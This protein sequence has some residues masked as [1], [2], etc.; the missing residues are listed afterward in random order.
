[1]GIAMKSLFLKLNDM[2]NYFLPTIKMYLRIMKRVVNI[3][4]LAILALLQIE[5]VVQ[6]QNVIVLSTADS[7]NK[8]YVASQYIEFLPGYIYQANST[9]EMEAYIYPNLN[10]LHLED[11]FCNDANV[12]IDTELESTSAPNATSYS[13]VVEDLQEGKKET[14]KSDDH[15]FSLSELVT[16]DVESG[17]KFK[18]LVIAR[19]QKGIIVGQG[20]ACI[21]KVL[22]A[23]TFKPF[24]PL[25]KKVDAGYVP[26]GSDKVLRF[27]YYE[28]YAVNS[29]DVEIL[30]SLSSSVY[31]GTINV[32]TGSNDL[33]MDLSQL[34]AKSFHTLQITT[35]KNE[36]W[37]LRFRTPE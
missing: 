13:F 3:K 23:I 15:I 22:S 29:V 11:K 27:N 14:I 17:K 21:I 16:I 37:Y 26:V 25:V 5:I 4:V 20:P 6:G 32:L 19:N 10:T 36:K 8:K 9:Q 33:K 30:N 1:M 2:V 35:S 7:D 31:K 12:K 28:H 34:Q 18:V 24:T